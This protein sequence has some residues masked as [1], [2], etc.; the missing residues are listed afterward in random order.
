M[1][2]ELENIIMNHDYSELTSE[3]LSLM[4]DWASTEEEYS[5]MRQILTSAPLLNSDIAPSPKLK[6]SL[7]ETFAAAHPAVSSSGVVSETD[8]SNRKVI[9]MWYKAIA[10]VA[11]IVLAF[12][13]VY[14]LFN[15]SDKS[16]MVAEN[17]LPKTN[18]SKNNDDSQ[19]KTNKENELDSSITESPIQTSQVNVP[20]SRAKIKNS[21][22]PPISNSEASSLNDE[23]V[24]KDSDYQ[25]TLFSTPSRLNTN[26]NDYGAGSVSTETIRNSP[27]KSEAITAHSDRIN[28]ADLPVQSRSVVQDRPEL[29]DLLHA[30]F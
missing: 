10:S 17:K 29:L 11:A 24:S 12:F 27:K 4:N 9:F 28:L 30:S 7:M 1:N 16:E 22:V 14:P 6:T 23:I 25:G 5:T 3:Q 15:S 26:L 18:Q 20:Q 8:N 13:L 2:T 19:T 21:F